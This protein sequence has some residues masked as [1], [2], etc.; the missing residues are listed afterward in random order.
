MPK[1]K[2]NKIGAF[3]FV[4]YCSLVHSVDSLVRVPSFSCAVPLTKVKKKTKA[5]KEGIITAVRNYV[6]Q[7]AIPVIAFS[8]SHISS[9]ETKGGVHRRYPSIY[10]VRYENMRNDKFK[11]L[12]E[13]LQE[14]SK[15]VVPPPQDSW[16][17]S[18]DFSS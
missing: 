12:R 2:R 15:Y 10:L 1:S 8:A 6:D 16:T 17:I 7:Y 18:L 4:S 11:E 3:V 5:W 9:D 13:E 14:T